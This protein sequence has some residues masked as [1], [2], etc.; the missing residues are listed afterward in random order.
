MLHINSLSA[1]FFR[2]LLV[3]DDALLRKYMAT[4]LMVLGFRKITEVCNGREALDLLQAHRA[5]FRYDFIIT[6]W[7]MPEMT[8]LELLQEIRRDVSLLDY[9]IPVLMCTGMAQKRHVLEARDYGTTEFIAKPF[10][11]QQLAQK[12]TSLLESPRDF[13]IS[14]EYIGPCR[15][16]STLALP[17]GMVERRRLVLKSM[18]EQRA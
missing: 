10:T 15:R 1:T 18:K 16:R 5:G 9:A 2:V 12:L 14:D 7:E 4:T 8:G 6:D 13:I 3:E 11:I 17:E